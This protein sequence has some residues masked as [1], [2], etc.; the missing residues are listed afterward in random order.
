VPEPIV[1]AY[2]IAVDDAS[3]MHVF[4]PTLSGRD[5]DEGGIDGEVEAYQDLVQKV[6]N[7]LLLQRPRG[8][9]TMKISAEQLSHE[10]AAKKGGEDE[11]ERWRV[12]NTHISSKGEMKTSLR[13]II[14]ETR[15]LAGCKRRNEIP[16]F[17]CWICLRS[18]SSR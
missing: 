17:S 4:E 11:E 6:L 15:E 1:S 13:L 5:K 2:K 10:I 14:W 18:L 3:R 12:R 7:E 16:T 9:E 8:K